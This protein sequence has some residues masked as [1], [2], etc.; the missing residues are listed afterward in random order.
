MNYYEACRELLRSD[1]LYEKQYLWLPTLKRPNSLN[2]VC[3]LLV[4]PE[5]QI[6]KDLSFPAEKDPAE[7]LS[8]V[9]LERGLLVYGFWLSVNHMQP[10][11]ME[12]DEWHIGTEAELLSYVRR[13][14]DDV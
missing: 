3:V 8:A 4:D 2:Q 1:D 12:W 14:L 6:M 13:A 7:E 11:R 5:H 10:D 9:W